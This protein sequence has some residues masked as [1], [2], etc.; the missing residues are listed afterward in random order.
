MSRR[1]KVE[2][3]KSLRVY[4][5]LIQEN[6]VI[7]ID[8]ILLLALLFLTP[9]I[10]KL[11]E[12]TLICNFCT[13]PVIVATGIVV[14]VIRLIYNKGSISVSWRSLS[15]YFLL[16]FM[17]KGLIM[18]WILLSINYYLANDDL[19]IETKSIV[20]DF[21]KGPNGVR[22]VIIENP[23]KMILIGRDYAQYQTIDLTLSKGFFGIDVIRGYK[24]NF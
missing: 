7:F 9:S 8:L 15:L 11:E 18:V 5:E 17:S 22:F 21:R 24:L 12:N 23:D 10:K 6:F 19:K 3:F 13:V 2:Y 14:I 16:D 20:D 4:I 1:R